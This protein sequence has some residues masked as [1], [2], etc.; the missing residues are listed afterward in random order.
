[1]TEVNH[2]SDE[3]ELELL[4]YPIGRFAASQEKPTAEA[5]RESIA[6][7]E[8]LAAGLRAAV[9]PLTAEQLETSYRPGG[10]TV[11]QV[12]HHLADTGMY[13]YLRFKRG[14]TED[15]PQVPS[16]RQD[17]WAEQ[18]DYSEEPAST[19]LELIELL[20]QRFARLLHSLTPADYDR[21]FVS[22]GLGAMTL[23]TA[24]ERYI[25]HSRHHTAQI[26]ALIRRSGW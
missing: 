15:A 9:E 1:M 25:W 6:V 21:T 7:I 12:V 24:V 23:D 10:W 22:G 26:T 3:Q 19:S 8:Q 20:N 18:S 13:G 14:L 4:K 17:L 2:N 5:R 16:Y 11:K